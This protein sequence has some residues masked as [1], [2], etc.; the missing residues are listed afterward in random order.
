MAEEVSR[1][2]NGD[3][4]AGRCPPES[5]RASLESAHRGESNGIGPKASTCL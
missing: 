4:S 1:E 5:G 2:K 3:T